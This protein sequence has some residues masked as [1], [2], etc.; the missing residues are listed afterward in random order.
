MISF[1]ISLSAGSLPLSTPLILSLNSSILRAK[2][3]KKALAW[4]RKRRKLDINM[5]KR[6]EK[7]RRIG[8]EWIY[9]IF[10]CFFLWFSNSAFIRD[11]FTLS[12]ES[13]AKMSFSR[14]SV[15][16]CCSSPY[17]SL[18]FWRMFDSK[19][20]S[21]SC[22][23]FLSTSICCKDY[24]KVFFSNYFLLFLEANLLADSF[25]Q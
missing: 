3:N 2:E 14:L 1:F 25:A 13:P 18:C 21:A 16:I 19:S 11:S 22:F 12:S 10:L 15:L 5:E 20:L 8:Q 23:V 6:K 9:Y 7:K 24:N 17:S 4:E